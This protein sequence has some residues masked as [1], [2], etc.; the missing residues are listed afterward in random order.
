MQAP[1]ISAGRGGLAL[2]NESLAQMRASH[3]NLAQ[4]FG[5]FSEHLHKSSAHVLN[6]FNNEELKAYQRLRDSKA[7]AQKDR[8]A[9]LEQERFNQAQ[10]QQ[11][12]ENTFREK[13]WNAQQAQQAIINKQN[14]QRLAIELSRNKALN[15]LSYAQSKAQNAQATGMNIDNFYKGHIIKS[16]DDP[17]AIQFGNQVQQGL[18]DPTYKKKPPLN[19]APTFPMNR[20]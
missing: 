8:A 18:L 11:H 4:A 20:E 10:A 5:Q 9:Q 17:K 16:A 3:Q 14:A 13:Q 6:T 19:T 15:A 12:L 7:D 2:F 1:D